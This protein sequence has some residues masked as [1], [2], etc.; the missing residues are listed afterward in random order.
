M[1]R[2]R[3]AAEVQSASPLRRR[4]P[5][6]PGRPSASAEADAVADWLLAQGRIGK[7][8]L[9]HARLR[10][11]RSEGSVLDQLRHRDGIRED[12]IADALAHLYH[13]ERLTLDTPADADLVDR[14]GAA[15]A[16]RHDILPWRRVGAATL[17]AAPLLIMARR[18]ALRRITSSS[19]AAPRETSDDL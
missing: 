5:F 6:D 4:S 2:H 7:A 14:F 17:I 9:D 19:N 3:S 16:I 10:M 15:K 13:A 1:F 11:T 8:S 12:D 18:A